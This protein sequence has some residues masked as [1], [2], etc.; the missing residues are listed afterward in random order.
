MS[1][2]VSLHL[3]VFLTHS[4]ST[5]GDEASKIQHHQESFKKG[6]IPNLHIVY[7]QKL[8]TQS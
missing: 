2:F 3:Y 1:L 8:L 7:N 6:I 5:V 4:E